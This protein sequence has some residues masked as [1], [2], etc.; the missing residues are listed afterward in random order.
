MLELRTTLH[1]NLML[2]LGKAQI[3]YK[4]CKVRCPFKAVLGSSKH[5]LLRQI[6]EQNLTVI[7][8][9]FG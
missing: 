4:K 7:S 6:V 9:L 8:L 2:I 5:V 3:R 1:T